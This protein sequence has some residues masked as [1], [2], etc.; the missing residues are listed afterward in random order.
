MFKKELPIIFIGLSVVVAT[1]VLGW[2]VFVKKE[3]VAPVRVPVAD[4][5]NG[6]IIP[7]DVIPD[8]AEDDIS[9]IDTSD[10]KTYRNEEYGFEMKYPDD[11]EINDSRSD[12]LYRS[13]EG[14]LI[15][16]LSKMLC[17]DFDFDNGMDIKVF[18]SKN[19]SKY[20][21][22]D[23]LL[24]IERRGV[25][26]EVFLVE[27]Y[28]YKNFEGVKTVSINPEMSKGEYIDLFLKINDGF[29]FFSW[30]AEDLENRGFTYTDYF[31]PMLSSFKFTES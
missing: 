19:K 30:Y 10:W 1:L 5:G 2:S 13:Y 14:R 28:S 23:D 15:L 16:E 27:K 4:D 31:I 20:P 26:E 29:Y 8:D 7:D 3:L 22:L 24:E 18:Y 6:E 9:E 11:F 25:A 21:N 12:K 17:C